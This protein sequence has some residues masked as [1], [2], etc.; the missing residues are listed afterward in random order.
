MEGMGGQRGSRSSAR[1]LQLGVKNRSVWNELG[2][3]QTQKCEM[4]PKPVG[5]LWT[6]SPRS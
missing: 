6:K 3:V 4:L 1:Y 5:S 2:K